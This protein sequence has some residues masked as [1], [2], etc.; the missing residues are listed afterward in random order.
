MPK[1]ITIAIGPVIIEK[2]KVLLN[3]EQKKE[4][5]DFF[6]FPGGKL[7]T[8]RETLE[9]ACA[10]EAKEELGIKIKI[11]QP[12]RPMIIKDKTNPKKI[13]V[14]IHYLAKRI[15]KIKPGK[16]TIEWGWFDIN[17]LPKNCAKN[18][19]EVMKDLKLN[20]NI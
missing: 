17:K 12:V 1:N 13:T 9:Q 18:V 5:S 11:I 2:N 8:G 16:Q 19:I 3:R 14:L 7:M 4:G 20:K 6:M 10:R 15:G